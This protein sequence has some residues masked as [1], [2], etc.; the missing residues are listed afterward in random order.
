MYWCRCR[1]QRWWS[2][3]PYYNEVLYQLSYSA[4]LFVG[5]YT[6]VF[7]LY[8]IVKI[9]RYLVQW[10]KQCQLLTPAAS[11]LTLPSTPEPGGGFPTSYVE[12]IY[13]Y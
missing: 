1:R 12:L 6:R 10:D 13:V 2:C 8:T 3:P 5:G 9:Y 11:A 4:F 7:N